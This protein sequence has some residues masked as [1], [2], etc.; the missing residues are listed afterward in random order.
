M[1]GDLL[2]EETG[3][4]GWL[5][6][7][8]T[9]ILMSCLGQLLVENLLP[10]MHALFD[11]EGGQFQRDGKMYETRPGA[12]GTLIAG[13]FL[14]GGIAYFLQWLITSRVLKKDEEGVSIYN[15]VGILGLLLYGLQ[16]FIEVKV[17]A[18]IPTMWIVVITFGVIITMSFIS[19]KLGPQNSW[20]NM[21]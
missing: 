20:K 9:I 8:F 14:P 6:V 13:V 7:V 4:W 19:I 11:S 18:M 1:I 17:G 3:F 21:Y 16:V 10:V 15:T 5:F 2:E 12:G